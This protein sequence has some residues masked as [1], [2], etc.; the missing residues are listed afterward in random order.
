MRK[1]REAK[2]HT[3][4]KPQ[5]PAPTLFP[6]VI[7]VWSAFCFLSERRG[8]GPNGPVPI[9]VEAMDAY[10]EL[11]GRK[12]SPYV[13]QFMR[14]I[15]ALD[16]EYLRHFYDQQAKELEKAQKKAQSSGR[17]GLNRR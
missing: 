7:W 8:V 10:L 11:T 3:P 4:K 2:G 13:Q 9:T 17:V 15:P 14:F 16:R 5:E 6:D 12:T 1:M